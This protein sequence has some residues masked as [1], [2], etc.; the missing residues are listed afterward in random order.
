MIRMYHWPTEKR[1]Q[2]KFS[3]Y[4]AASDRSLNSAA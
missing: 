4:H 3:G 1:G 2:S